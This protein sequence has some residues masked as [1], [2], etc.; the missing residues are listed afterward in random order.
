MP[1]HDPKTDAG[2]RRHVQERR[3]SIVAQPVMDIESLTPLHDEWLVRFDS[4]EGLEGLLRPAE[5]SGAI[6]TLD[7]SMLEHA[8]KTLN[9]DKRRRPI[10]VNL[11]GA[12]MDNQHFEHLLF[13]TLERLN[14]E[15][16]RLIFE[17]TETWDLRDLRNTVEIL[18]RLRARG[19]AIC[20]DDVGAGAASIRYL[21]AFE[22][23]WLKID[24]GFVQD[25]MKKPRDLTILK[26]ILS[27]KSP[28]DVKII[29]E[30]IEDEAAIDFVKKLGFDAVQGFVFGEPV[31]EPLRGL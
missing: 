8:I 3:F 14:T 26:A 18:K 25:A 4:D 12:S 21:R 13:S 16:S 9:G 27:L 22:T 31:R 20:L 15:P 28:L 2:F 29:A 19:H 11:S 30:G 24:G 17:L 5:I 1:H 7:I 10:A 6:A 23:D